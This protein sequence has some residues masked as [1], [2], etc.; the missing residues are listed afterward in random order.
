M[1][2][3]DIEI[4]LRHSALRPDP[5]GV[6]PSRARVLRDR[7]AARRAARLAGHQGR[8]P[9]T[10]LLARLAEMNGVRWILRLG[11]ARP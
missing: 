1:W 3:N 10:P 8:S 7:L 6:A 9:R 4:Q 2:F 5:A 11:R